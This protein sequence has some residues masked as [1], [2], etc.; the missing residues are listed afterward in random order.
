MTLEEQDL[1]SVVIPFYNEE[2]YFDDC[3]NSVLNQTY[4]NIEIII[5]DDGSDKKFYEK[6]RLL[7]QK[8]PNK[9]NLFHK[10]NGGVGSARNLGIQKA[11]GKYISFLDADDYWLPNKIKSR[12]FN[13]KASNYY[14]KIY[15]MKKIVNDFI[16]KQKLV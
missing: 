2:N 13:K 11:T 5:V 1:V 8:Y 4:Q 6:L 16:K 7:N 3:I 9:I 14:S 15:N 10:Q 12:K